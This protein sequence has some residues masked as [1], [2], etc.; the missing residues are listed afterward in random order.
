MIEIERSNPVPRRLKK[1]GARQTKIDCD[2]YDACPGGYETGDLK[3]LWRDHYSAKEVKNRLVKMHRCKCCYCEQ[4]FPPEYLHIEHFRPKGRVRQAPELAEHSPGYFWLAYR[5]DNLLLACQACNSFNKKTL[6]PLKKPKGRAQPCHD[7]VATEQPLFIDPTALD[8]R[9]HIRFAYDAP[10]G[11]SPEGDTTIRLIGLRRPK[12]LEDR[13]AQIKHINARLAILSMA[14]EYPGN[15][16]IKECA[17]E[18]RQFIEHAVRPEAPF[19]SMAID[20]LA[21]H[22]V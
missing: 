2:A 18:A 15:V 10:A 11:K 7:G 6:F 5:W 1:Q 3:F 17:V 4:V 14:K 21:H 20:Y 13:L 22:S 16:K 9:A 19:S 8:P 12:L